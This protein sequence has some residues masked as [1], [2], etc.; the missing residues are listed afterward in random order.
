MDNE[1]FWNYP[2]PTERM[3]PFDA[4]ATALRRSTRPPGLSAVF[5]ASTARRADKFEGVV[6]WE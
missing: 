4:A 3:A 1:I 2:T 5:V 6:V